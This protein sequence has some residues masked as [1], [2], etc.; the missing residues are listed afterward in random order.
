VV[1]PALRAAPRWGEFFAP[2][3]LAF[4]VLMVTNDRILKPR[5]HS[6][7]TGKLSDVAV[8]FFMPLFVSELL[9]L[10]AGLEPR[11]RLRAGAVF[12][13]VLY[14]ALEVVP[15]VTRLALR[16]LGTVGPWVGIVAPF[17]M[18][19][20]WT[21]LLCLLELPLTVAYGEWRLGV[22]R[23]SATLAVAHSRT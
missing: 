6:A 20:D 11:L 3:P 2:V 10:V 22:S 7:L 12:T 18:T 16:L 21:D 8:C 5:F 14:A 17:R 19:S 9:G 13:G 23:H 4:V 15:P 1:A